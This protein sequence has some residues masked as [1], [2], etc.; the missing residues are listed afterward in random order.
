MPCLL[1]AAVCLQFGSA[2]TYLYEMAPVGRKGFT[3]SFG[4]VA[5]SPVSV[6]L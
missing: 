3:A 2:I 4:Q 1:P 6:A 5:V